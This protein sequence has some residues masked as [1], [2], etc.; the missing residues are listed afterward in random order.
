MESVSKRETVWEQK[1]R[2]GSFVTCFDFMA[3][4]PK[5]LKASLLVQNHTSTELNMMNT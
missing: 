2:R 4:K 5:S 3:N 1:S